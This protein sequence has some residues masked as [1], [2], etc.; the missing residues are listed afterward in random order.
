MASSNVLPFKV[1]RSSAGG[2]VARLVRPTELRILLV[3]DDEV[4]AR[5]FRWVAHRIG[6][7]PAQVTVA[8][9]IEE[10]RALIEAESFDLH[11]LDFWLGAET[12]LEL[13]DQLGRGAD[14]KPVLVLSNL[15]PEELVY[16]GPPGRELRVL[17]KA[18]LAPA[19]L[20]REID[21]LVLPR[22]TRARAAESK[23]ASFPVGPDAA[24]WR[25]V[26]DQ[27]EDL[28]SLS[29]KIS[30]FIAMADGHLSSDE[31]EDAHGFVADAARQLPDLDVTLEELEAIVRR[32]TTG[33]ANEA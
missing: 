16:V 4:D 9:T 24:A 10:A 7:E 19:S 27:I 26:L 13:I 22:A 5:L 12:S 6:I 21:R 23:T 15:S 14:R 30:T 25:K 11:V 3:E 20:E 8:A 32:R 33:S 1:A 31:I 17:S 2:N 18:D 29:Q 28:K